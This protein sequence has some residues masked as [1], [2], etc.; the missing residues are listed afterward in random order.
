MAAMKKR[1]GRIIIYI[2]LIV[3]AAAILAYLLLSRQGGNTLGR[4]E[5]TPT[6]SYELVDIV[7]ASQ[8]IP[9]GQ[10]ITRDVLTTIRYPKHE[11][12]PGTFFT[13]PDEVVGSRP[14]YNI[15][16][17]VP[18][19]ANMLL[20]ADGGSVASFDI[21]I[22]MTAY[23]LATSPETAVAYAPQKGDHVMVVGCMLFTEVDS[24]YQTVLPNNTTITYGSGSTGC[25]L[26]TGECEGYTLSETILPYTPGVTSSIG[27]FEIDNASDESIYVVPSET[28]RPRL[29]CQTIIQD[30]T[31]LQ[32]GMFPLGSSE[33]AVQATPTEVVAT[34]AVPTNGFINPGSVTIVV[35][36]QDTV[37]L[38]YL[39]LSGAKL[40]LAL[41]SALQGDP[42][43]TDPVTLQYIMDQ[44]NVPA[45]VK[46]PYSVEPRVD[47][48]VYP[49]FEEYIITE[50]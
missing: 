40:S 18:I 49:T 23:S 48:L 24:S 37:V 19:S 30:A 47:S 46:L 32:V 11:L 2:L 6:L 12:V 38:N 42:F 26:G 7:V 34:E 4:Q 39:A 29:V 14:K 28:Q 45:P 33:S 1:T 10:V 16:S 21:P 5:P 13:S 36:P 9:R 35:S 15:D 44:K 3:I 25:S 8:Y 27:R 41:K 20:K 31:V 17:A 50:P 22:G 43:S